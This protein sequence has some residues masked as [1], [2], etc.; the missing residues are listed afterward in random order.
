[1]YRNVQSKMETE[2]QLKAEQ[3]TKFNSRSRKEKTKSAIEE[4]ENRN[5]RN[6]QNRYITYR[7]TRQGPKN[8]SRYKLTLVTT[9]HK[10]HQTFM[11]VLSNAV[12]NVCT[13]IM[14]PSKKN[15]KM[16]AVD[17]E[18]APFPRSNDT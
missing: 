11:S 9:H 8:F 6:S 12:R 18:G 4:T 10:Y 3:V 15:I 14:S 2:I 13:A 7:R 1:M 16:R 17:P 5:F